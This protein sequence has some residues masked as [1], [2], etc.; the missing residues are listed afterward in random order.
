[1][2]NKQW[3]RV[4]KHW[5]IIFACRMYT[6][7]P[8]GHLFSSCAYLDLCIHPGGV[9]SSWTQSRWVPIHSWGYFRRPSGEFNST[10]IHIVYCTIIPFDHT[11]TERTYTRNEPCSDIVIILYTVISHICSHNN[12]FFISCYNIVLSSGVCNLWVFKAPKEKWV[13]PIQWPCLHSGLSVR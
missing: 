6:A 10:V 7:A 12:L 9:G 13:D 1:M 2:K 3:R 8:L 4:V 5:D 11:E